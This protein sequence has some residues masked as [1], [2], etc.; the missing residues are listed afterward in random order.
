MDTN[1]HPNQ[2]LKVKNIIG[3]DQIHSSSV[4]GVSDLTPDKEEKYRK[5]SE[6]NLTLI[7]KELSNLFKRTS[8]PLNK[9]L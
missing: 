6:H 7:D 4:I 3:I 2:T 1:A 9:N 5:P 8:V